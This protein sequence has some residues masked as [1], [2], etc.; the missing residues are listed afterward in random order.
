MPVPTP[1]VLWA[2][3]GAVVSSLNDEFA[4]EFTA[5]RRWLPAASEEELAS[6]RVTVSPAAKVREQ[7]S[8]SQDQDDFSIEIGIQKK[9]GADADGFPDDEEID[10]VVLIATRISDLFGAATDRISGFD[11]DNSQQAHWIETTHD[12]VVDREHLNSRS[13]VT[14]LVTLIFRVIR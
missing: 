8:R 14:S 6:L 12:P 11:L 2:I 7:L 9:V 3:A 4:G 1:S 10:A 5:F 13:V